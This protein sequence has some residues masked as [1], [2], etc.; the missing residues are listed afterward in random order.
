VV[1][2]DIA[3]PEFA[4][5]GGSA[6]WLDP[7]GWRYLGVAFLESGAVRRR[8][9]WRRSLAYVPFARVQSVS[10]RQ[11]V[12]QRRLALAT[13]HLDVPRGSMRW[14]ADHRDHDEAAELV[15]QLSGRQRHG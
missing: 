7:V 9:R 12:L 3:A 1:G 10:A 13:V 14:T 2:A 4:P 8:G 6:R 11:G 15:R 5:A